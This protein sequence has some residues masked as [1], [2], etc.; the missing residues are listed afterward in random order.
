MTKKRT[1]IYPGTFDPVTFGHIDI[2]FRALKL[3]DYLIV[4]VALNPLKN[5]MFALDSRVQ[6]I[7]QGVCGLKNIDV[8]PFNNLLTDFAKLK[9]ASVII[10]GLRAVSDF[11]YELQM[12]LM[13]RNLDENLE[14]LFMIPSQEFSFLSPSFVREIARHGGDV[15]RMV[16]K[17]V[18]QGMK[19]QNS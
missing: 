16:P 17:G 11:E 18:A 13:N 14:T 8:L 12:G 15:S 9:K 3:F 7:R 2:M 6:F 19:N 10:K 4:A 5:P 1:A